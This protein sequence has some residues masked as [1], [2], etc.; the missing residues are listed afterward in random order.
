[1]TVKT[2]MSTGL[3]INIAQIIIKGIIVT[4]HNMN[5]EEMTIIMIE[6]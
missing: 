1:M 4:P 6:T 5:T 3:L 2:A